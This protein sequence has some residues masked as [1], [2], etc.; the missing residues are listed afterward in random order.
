MATEPVPSSARLATAQTPTVSASKPSTHD[1][2]RACEN[3][4][5]IV[6]VALERAPTLQAMHRSANSIPPSAREALLRLGQPNLRD[7]I[8]SAE[9][10]A[11]SPSTALT[12]S[13]RSLGGL[14]EPTPTPVV[15]E[16]LPPL[17][18]PMIAGFDH[19]TAWGPMGR[20]S[21]EPSTL[22]IEVRTLLAQVR[23]QAQQASSQLVRTPAIAE[24]G[25]T[26]RTT[27]AFVVIVDPRVAQRIM[28][29]LD[30]QRV[31]F[32]MIPGQNPF[33]NR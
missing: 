9:S 6:R 15:Q 5:R 14:A 23:N 28:S 17:R 20:L 4:K 30:R 11:G 26:G 7:L 32:Q 22:D 18:S 25:A 31:T 2:A 19:P 1:S 3:W 8:P 13:P 10:G 29:V 12:V 24:G 16:G 27:R 33:F 21:H